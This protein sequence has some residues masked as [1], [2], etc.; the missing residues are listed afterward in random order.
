[1]GI[2]TQAFAIAVADAIEEEAEVAPEIVDARNAGSAD[3]ILDRL[4]V[5]A[6]CRKEVLHRFAQ[7]NEIGQHPLREARGTLRVHVA[8]ERT[9]GRAQHHI[10]FIVVR[11]EK[12]QFR[13]QD[14]C[15][16][17]IATNLRIGEG[18]CLGFAG[19]LADVRHLGEVHLGV[20]VA[21][22]SIPANGDGHRLSPC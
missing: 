19:Q 15:P 22:H 16:V 13:R 11:G 18:A 6:I 4:T 2:A 20:V 8:P 9:I 17:E 12:A 3:E 1:M 14:R 10:E 7:S 21:L 5:G